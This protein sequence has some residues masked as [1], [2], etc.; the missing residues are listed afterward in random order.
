MCGCS[1][2]NHHSLK[3]SAMSQSHAPSQDALIAALVAFDTD[4][5]ILVVAVQNLADVIYGV[6]DTS[7]EV[8]EQRE[9]YRP[10]IDGNFHPML[11]PPDDAP[12][13]EWMLAFSSAFRKSTSA[14]DRKLQ[15]RILEA[16]NELSRNPLLMRGD[17]V[18]PLKHDRKSLW[19]YRIDDYRLVYRPNIQLRRIDLIAFDAR[20]SIYE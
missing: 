16:I 20:G 8:S 18:K 10:S 17:T 2:P 1:E 9:N 4:D 6:S 13:E 15:G 3:G 19:R 14:I 5:A 12:F 7:H 11:L